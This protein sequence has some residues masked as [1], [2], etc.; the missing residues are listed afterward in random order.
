MGVRPTGPQ[1]VEPLPPG[2]FVGCTP[3][4]KARP[5]GP[6]ISVLGGEKP[7][8]CG[9]EARWILVADY[10]DAAWFLCDEHFDEAAA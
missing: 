7:G 4:T 10:D 9:R 5:W 2:S 8:G 1:R 6:P 3:P